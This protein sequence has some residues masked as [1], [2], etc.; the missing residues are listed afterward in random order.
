MP[1]PQR[2]GDWLALSSGLLWSITSVLLRSDRGTSAIELFTH[3]FLWSGIVAFDFALIA[4]P[5]LS[6]APTLSRCLEQLPWLVPVIVIVVMSG[7]YATMW[8][9]P[10]LSPGIVGLLFMTEISVGAVTAALWSGDPFGWPEIIGI[11][12][13]TTAGLLESLRDLALARTV[14]AR[15]VR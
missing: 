1:S 10:K 7:V 15:P 2:T 3:N 11:T 8:G 9:T 12:L 14:R 6:A 13:I 5:T 4:Q